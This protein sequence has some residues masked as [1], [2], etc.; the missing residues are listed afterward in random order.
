M[1]VWVPYM[2]RDGN[3]YKQHGY[4]VVDRPL[5]NE[6]IAAVKATLIGGE[7]FLPQLIDLPD[8]QEEFGTWD[9]EADHPWHEIDLEGQEDSHE[10]AADLTTDEFVR[11]MTTT[12]WDST[13]V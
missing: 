7:Y 11:R 8:L 10:S 1:S 2:Y 3:N 6:E 5:T 4:I 13:A 12:V 9:D